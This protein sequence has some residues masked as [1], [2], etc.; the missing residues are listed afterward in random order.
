MLGLTRPNDRLW[1]TYV[2]FVADSELTVVVET[3]RE[4]LSLFVSV[5]GSMPSTKDVSALFGAN[6]LNLHVLVFTRFAT[7]RFGDAPDFTTFSIAPG[8]DLAIRGQC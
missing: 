5:E 2:L 1:C 7:T 8:P 3:P 4:E 6:L